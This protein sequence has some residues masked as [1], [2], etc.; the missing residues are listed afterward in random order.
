[1]RALRLVRDLQIPNAAIGAGAVRNWIWDL[2]HQRTPS[3]RSADIDVVYFDEQDLDATQELKWQMQLQNAMP[4][5]TWEVVNQA[6][7]H[8][9]MNTN[10]KTDLAAFQSVEQA[11]ASWPET[12]TC[13]AVSMGA[14]EQIKVIAPYGLVD[15]FELQLRPNL[16]CVSQAIFQQRLH[17]K[18]F[19]QRWQQLK[20]DPIITSV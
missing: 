14:E 4:E 1:M 7:V 17:E 10:N 6:C 12:A 2:A 19:L 8:R 3:L 15:L 20:F 13:V 11:I 5:F 9:W 18:R 16:S